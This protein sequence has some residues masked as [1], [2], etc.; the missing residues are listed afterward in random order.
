MSKSI[1]F[2]SHIEPEKEVAIAFKDLIEASFLGMI[3]IFVSSD[4]HSIAM[5]AAV[6]RRYHER[7]ESV[8][9]RNCS[10]QLSVN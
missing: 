2:I 3:E 10:L 7:V 4:Q 1:V 5:G 6:A 9:H 8:L